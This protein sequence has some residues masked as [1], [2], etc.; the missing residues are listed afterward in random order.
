MVPPEMRKHVSILAS[1]DPKEYHMF[2]PDSEEGDDRY[3]FLGAAAACHY[4]L[5]TGQT[6]GFLEPKGPMKH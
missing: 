6:E 5:E 2:D 3:K 4:A 1:E